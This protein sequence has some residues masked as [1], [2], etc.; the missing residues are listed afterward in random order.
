MQ[1]PPG[2]ETE[3]TPLP[4]RVESRDSLLRKYDIP[5][6]HLDFAYVE[7]CTDGKEL[8]RILHI[9]QSGE[10]GY[11]PQLMTAT[12]ERLSLIKP[13]SKFIRKVT[14]V[15]DK[16]ELD[17]KSKTELE[18]EIDIF[19]QNA[20]Q[21]DTELGK[22][23]KSVN[24]PQS[25]PEVRQTRNIENTTVENKSNRIK[26]TDYASWDKY[27]PDTE[28]L[29]M[30]LETEQL[31]KKHQQQE[32]QE[33]LTKK[34]VKFENC[35]NET[36]ASIQSNQE[37]LKG[38]EYYKSAE[39]KEAL[40]CYTNS[41]NMHPSIEAYNNRAQVY[42][43]LQEYQL[44]MAD[45]QSVLTHNPNNVKA[46]MRLAQSLNACCLYQD[47]IQHLEKIIYLD[48][49]HENAQNL[50]NTVKSKHAHASGGKTRMKITEISSAAPNQSKPK[51]K[52]ILKKSQCRANTNKSNESPVLVP[53]PGPS[54]MREPYYVVLE[55]KNPEI[56]KRAQYML[57]N[58]PQMMYM[59]HPD[60]SDEESEEPYENNHNLNHN[61]C[62]NT[63][64]LNDINQR[65]MYYAQEKTKKSTVEITELPNDT[66]IETD[67]A[68]DIDI[69]ENSAEVD[70]LDNNN[71]SE[72]MIDDLN[73][74]NQIQEVE[75]G[76]S[77][78]PH[79]NNNNTE[80]NLTSGIETPFSFLRAWLAVQRDDSYVK[81]AKVLQN[82]DE[83]HLNEVIGYK[84]DGTMLTD[85]LRTLYLHFSVPHEV[86]RVRAILTNM[87]ELPRFRVVSLFI[88][89]ADKY[90]IRS[91]FEF[92]EQH[93]TP[94]P[95]HVKNKY[96]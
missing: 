88:T 59:C 11:Y 84:L 74:N 43:M 69:C 63:T 5:I 32:K 34:E 21:N 80:N 82:I 50:L 71:K 62:R 28:I 24:I 40:E 42:I 72:K 92:L 26:A 76:G 10:E 58:K 25:I 79:L 18:N 55:D 86:E 48:P 13:T 2:S 93:G 46:L 49:N 36:E 6:A 60:D 52:S 14:A 90:K 22:F 8:E 56:I 23:K 44:A 81:H 41:I 35:Y 67:S 17:I 45:C 12:E 66:E 30:D 15:V 73:N 33:K 96:L 91:L 87:A 95:E 19:V 77:G 53:I 64:T 39:Y 37:R 20:S 29:K 83:N 31:Q 65:I 78:E 3:D 70:L 85:I 94:L 4:S 7:K 89:S 16:H 61:D 75:D 47:A 1:L 54:H 27:D 51:R 38:N 9:L 57:Y 68:I